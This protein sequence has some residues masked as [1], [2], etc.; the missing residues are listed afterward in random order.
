[1]EGL[2]RV[3]CGGHFAVLVGVVGLIYRGRVGKRKRGTGLGN[4]VQASCNVDVE[5]RDGLCCIASSMVFWRLVADKGFDAAKVQAYVSIER[6]WYLFIIQ[7]SC[8]KGVQ[9]RYSYATP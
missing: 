8:S 4:E 7:Q 6:D 9:Y 3:L 5:G 2:G 1:M